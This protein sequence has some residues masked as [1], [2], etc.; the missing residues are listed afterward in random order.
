MQE[1]RL[2][3]S[4]ADVV[5]RLQTLVLT[6]S[7]VL[8]NI[9]LAAL[10]GVVV[11]GICGAAILSFGALIGKSG[12]TGTEYVGYWTSSLIWLGLLYGGL[13]GLLVAP[14]G[15]L[16]LARRVGIRGAFLPATAGTLIGG[17]LGAFAA[18]PLAVITGI[19]GFVLGLLWA[20][21][22]SA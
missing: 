17:F 4:R 5:M 12:T 18:P 22:R 2:L 3:F 8:L 7:R 21:L 19:C 9:A 11:G 20:N 10:L 13:F 14:L 1:H 16:L 15:Y 6:A